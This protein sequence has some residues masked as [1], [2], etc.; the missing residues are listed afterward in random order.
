ML[1]KKLTKETTKLFKETNPYHTDIIGTESFSIII[2]D[3]DKGIYT[4][5]NSKRGENSVSNQHFT[6]NLQVA[7]KTLGDLNNL[8]KTFTGKDLIL[9]DQRNDNLSCG[10]Q[11][12]KY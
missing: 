12:S 10:K 8:W 9:V 6:P 5:V 7:L 11:L 1:N 3:F 2:E 4:L